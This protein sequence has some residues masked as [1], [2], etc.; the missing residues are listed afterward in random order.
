NDWNALY[1]GSGATTKA[2]VLDRRYT[3]PGAEPIRQ[4]L[5][6]W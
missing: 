2:I 6:Q 3:N 1:Y 4:Y 5:A